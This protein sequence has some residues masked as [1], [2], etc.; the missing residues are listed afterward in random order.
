VKTDHASEDRRGGRVSDD[1]P[2]LKVILS[3]FQTIRTAMD[4]KATSVLTIVSFNATVIAAVLGLV[5]SKKADLRLLLVL[6]FVSSGLGLMVLDLDRDIMLARAYIKDTLQPLAAE[7]TQDD[8]VLG[9]ANSIPRSRLMIFAAQMIPFAL[10][11][12]I[13]SLIALIVVIGHLNSAADWS[14]WCLGLIL[15][16][17][18]V[19]VGSTFIWQLISGHKTHHHAPPQLSTERSAADGTGSLPDPSGLT[20]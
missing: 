3:E 18:L 8:R 13:V 2:A 17:V 7:Y 1:P 14:A 9:Y 6:P 15:L 16:L 12:P 19:A 10:L 20:L 4:R 5:L 11:F